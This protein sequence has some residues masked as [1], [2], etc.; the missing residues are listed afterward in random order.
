MDW[1]LERKTDLSFLKKE[2]DYYSALI[3]FSAISEKKQAKQILLQFQELVHGE[4]PK[5]VDTVIQLEDKLSVIDGQPDA[6]MK[7][8]FSSIQ[9]QW[10][11]F[12]GK[13]V[14]TKLKLLEA[15]THHYPLTII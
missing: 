7:Q 10:S 2:N 15:I 14:A 4:L 8:N 1:V 13:Y 3:R 9:K 11:E 5:M 6:F 12:K